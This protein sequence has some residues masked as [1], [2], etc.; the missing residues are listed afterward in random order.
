MEIPVDVTDPSGRKLL[1]MEGLFSKISG[2]SW[3][4]ISMGEFQL[5]V[6]LS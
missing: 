1:T 3:K 2:E 6:C 5:I 4:T